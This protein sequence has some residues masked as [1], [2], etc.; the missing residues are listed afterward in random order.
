MEVNIDEK[1]LLEAI[2]D[3]ESEIFRMSRGLTQVKRIA[4]QDSIPQKEGEDII[5][6]AM[7]VDSIL[8]R[9][10]R[11][12]INNIKDAVDYHNLKHMEELQ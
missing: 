4:M 2:D 12:T 1:K 9:D 10:L 6:K 8:S 7:Q 3:L 5:Q 11:V